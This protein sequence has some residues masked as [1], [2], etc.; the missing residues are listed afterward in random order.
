MSFESTNKKEYDGYRQVKTVHKDRKHWMQQ[1]VHNLRL[2][3]TNKGRGLNANMQEIQKA[4]EE[5][6][7]QEEEF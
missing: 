4:N 1:R 5:T 3:N 6:S 2:C 7:I